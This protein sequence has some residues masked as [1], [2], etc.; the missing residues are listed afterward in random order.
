MVDAMGPT[1]AGEMMRHAAAYITEH[2]SLLTR[3][4]TLTAEL[5]RVEKLVH[6]VG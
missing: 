5:A 3:I 1:R 4:Q 2:E 6:N